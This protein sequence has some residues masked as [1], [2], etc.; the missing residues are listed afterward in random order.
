MPDLV[1]LKIVSFLDW[2]KVRTAIVPFPIFFCDPSIYCY[3]V[4][5]DARIVSF[6]L[7][8]S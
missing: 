8:C 5:P 7:F 6:K 4:M 1:F 2:D 3:K